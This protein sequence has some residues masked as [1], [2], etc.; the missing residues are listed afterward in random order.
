MNKGKPM[1]AG[2]E[3]AP[4]VQGGSTPVW[5]VLS[6]GLLTAAVACL[7]CYE[8]TRPFNGHHD[9]N[10]AYMS[11]AARNHLRYGFLTTKFGLVVDNGP[12]T[13]QGFTYYTHHPPL[14]PV[15]VAFFFLLFGQHEWVAR[16]VP[17]LFSI[18]S[19]LL[20]YFIG[21]RLMGRVLGVVS[22][23][24]FGFYPMTLYFG[25]MLDHEA[26]TQFFVLAAIL[27]YMHWRRERRSLF[28]RLMIAAMVL[29][30]LCGWPGYYV[31]LVLPAHSFVTSRREGF[32]RRIL[33]LPAIAVFLFLVHLG[34]QFL[35]DGSG[36]LSGLWQQ[37]AL[38]TGLSGRPFGLRGFAV[39]HLHRLP[40]LYTWPALLAALAYPLLALKFGRRLPSSDPWLIPALIAFGTMHLAL[41]AQGAW[42]HD[43]WTFYLSAGFALAGGVSIVWLSS[44]KPG[45]AL[46]G[47]VLIMFL[48]GG[49]RTALL[50]HTWDYNSDR[51]GVWLKAHTNPQEQIL[52]SA[53]VSW[54]D[55]TDPRTLY[56]AERNG[57]NREPV[58]DLKALNQTLNQR[59]RGPYAFLLFNHVSDAAG[60]GVQVKDQRAVEALR[61]R[62]VRE[63]PVED[64]AFDGARFE[65]FRIGA[66]DTLGS[67]SGPA[68]RE[69][70]AE[71]AGPPPI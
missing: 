47:A 57:A 67:D 35:L 62:L 51:L 53:G 48:W 25:R 68:R 59:P 9:F 69:G 16:L 41:F 6:L 29:A 31:G 17:I 64:C 70:A 56:Y 22:A 32:D 61:D 54:W 7:L 33:T 10:T 5:V 45:L 46:S 11:T 18:G 60:L 1:R 23:L 26:P 15:I 50:I 8:I 24:L 63:F 21:R 14:I 65:I 27:A 49:V 36:G 55:F 37:L 44:S 28:Y 58:T 40:Q 12:Q 52:K 43:Y 34:H 2:T 42:V 4:A 66:S 38:R 20:V 39:R 30:C 19:L 13:A 3:P 71:R